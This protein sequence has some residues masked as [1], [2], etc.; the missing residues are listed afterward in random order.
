MLD[1]KACDSCSVFCSLFSGERGSLRGLILKFLRKLILEKKY[2]FRIFFLKI[3][4]FCKYYL[5]VTAVSAVHVGV[6]VVGGTDGDPGRRGQQGKCRL[7][8]GCRYGQ[9]G[10]SLESRVQLD[11]IREYIYG[12]FD[13][14][15]ELYLMSKMKFIKKVG[16]H[17]VTR[18]KTTKD[19]HKYYN[20]IRLL[21]LKM[22][23]KLRVCI[24]YLQDNLKYY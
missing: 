2:N 17:M 15:V 19:F 12:C 11:Q 8:W 13:L 23:P 21:S 1:K 3:F 24:T 4:I 7:G 22:L 14:I 5:V 18:L 16:F 6:I 20:T 9:I 10:G